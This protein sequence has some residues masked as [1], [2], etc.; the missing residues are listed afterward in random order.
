MNVLSLKDRLAMEAERLRKKAEELLDG[1][2][3]DAALRK[4]SLAE[5]AVKLYATLPSKW[6]GDHSHEE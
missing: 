2:E 6:S 4:A 5:T 3:R 1:I